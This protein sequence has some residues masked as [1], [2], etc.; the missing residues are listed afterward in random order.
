[1][2]KFQIGAIVGAIVF[3]LILYL[4]F[5]TMPPKQ[6]ELEK[7]RIF[8]LESTS[9]SNLVQEAKAK[10]TPE[11]SSIIEAIHLDLNKVG[12]DSL[13]KV[14]ILK[15]LS[16]TWYEMGYPA[17]AGSYAQDIASIEKTGEAWSMAGTTYALCVKSDADEK[18]KEFCSKRAIKAFE[19]AISIMPDNVEARINLAIC[20]VDRPPTDNPMQ[21]ILILRDLNT[22]YPENVS[23]LNQ[24]GKLAL[25]TNQIDKALERLEKA[26]ELDPKNQNTICLLAEAYTT[27][28]NAAK[29]AEYNKKCIN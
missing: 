13:K 17:I 23:V 12:S 9:I 21:G 8:N 24:L 10:L 3:F 5:D 26:I 25:Q 19:N 4:G 29:A 16:G 15:S 28:K 18:T 1:M 2:S 11:Q 20:Y 7:S 27:I 6:K 22:K 14:V